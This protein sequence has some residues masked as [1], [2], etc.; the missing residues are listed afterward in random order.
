M[1]QTMKHR[2]GPEKL[3]PSDHRSWQSRSPYGITKGFR[4]KTAAQ[5]HA[6]AF[7]ESMERQGSIARATIWL[8]A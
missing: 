6:D 2:T 1:Q 4:S 3:D 5:H 8:G 7:N